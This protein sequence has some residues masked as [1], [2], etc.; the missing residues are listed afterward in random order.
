V[1]D[2]FPRPEVAERFL[3]EKVR[4]ETEKW[5]ELNWS[6]HVHAF[7]VAHSMNAGVLDTIHG[8][9]N[10]AAAE[11]ISFQDFRSGMLDMMKAKG[12]YGGAGHTADEKKY[13]N[14]RIG[15]MYD[16]N[17]RT[18]YSAERYRK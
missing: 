9:L 16:T 6:E 3:R 17:M 2:R 13:S 15:V 1:S 8:L 7:T 11:G 4:Y 5:D 14:W 18:A 10:R 12:W